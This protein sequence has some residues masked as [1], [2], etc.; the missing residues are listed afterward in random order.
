L[1]TNALLL[2]DLEA[3]KGMISAKEDERGNKVI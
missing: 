3:G 2:S 1:I